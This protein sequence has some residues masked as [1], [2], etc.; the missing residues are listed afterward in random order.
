LIDFLVK[1]LISLAP[2]LVFLV[3]LVHTDSFKLVRFRLVVLTM[4]SGAVLALLALVLNGYAI[5][6]LKL[7]LV[8]YSRYVAPVV[9][10][11]L[12]AI[13][14]FF[15]FRTNRIAF[16]IDSIIL[17]FAVGTG[18][19]LFENVYYL[20]TV[21]G[22]TIGDWVIRGFGTAIMHGATTAIFSGLLQTISANRPQARLIWGL[23]GFIAATVLHA[24]FNRFPDNPLL[25]T[26][27]TLLVLP[28]ALLLV[29]KKS[30]NAIHT[31]LVMDFE[32]HEHLIERLEHGELGET[33]GGRFILGLADRLDRPHFALIVDYIRL[34]TELVLQAETILLAR[35]HGN[36]IEIDPGVHAKFE[37]LHAD[38][39]KIG[40]TT[41][42]AISAHLHFTRAEMWELY[43]LEAR[44]RRPA[45][46]G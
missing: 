34:H 14:V 35:E 18:F 43:Q 19:A 42:M 36:E 5:S 3:A 13:A 27:P 20:W 40:K 9:E 41:L 46:N 16:A 6:A 23:P 22:A 11:L 37:R 38:E 31:W 28:V 17:G 26:I 33:A 24:I 15:L 44:S 45:S 30:A 12:K 39:R 25:S 1:S 21:A 8:T 7:D 4:V 32:H 2:V 10:E 29:F